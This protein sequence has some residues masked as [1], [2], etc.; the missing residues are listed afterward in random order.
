MTDA[1]PFFIGSDV[2]RRPGFGNNHPLAIPR[3]G[4]VMEICDSMD[5]FDGN[6][7]ESPEADDAALLRFHDRDYLEAV[8]RA[9]R[10]GRADAEDRARYA[11]GTMEN[12]IFEGL[13]KRA[14]TTCGG[15]MLAAEK[16]LAGGIAFNPAGGTHHGM[17]DRAHGFC[18]FND[19]VMAVMT[20]LDGGAGSVFYL[21]LDAHH[22]DGVEAAF[23]DE[24]RVVTLSIHERDRWP[25]TGAVHGAM[26]S[27]V[28]NYPVPKGFN[29]NELAALMSGAVLPLIESLSPDAA[30]VTCGADGLAADPLSGMMLSNIAL[31]DAVT[32]VTARVPGTVVLGGGGYNPWTVARCWSGFWGRLSGRTPPWPLTEEIRIRFDEI[33]CDL[34]DDED[35]DQSWW[36]RIEDD[37]NLAPVRPEIAALIWGAGTDWREVI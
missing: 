7:L 30:V 9:A 34:I 37:A 11:L 21:D 22:G 8:K 13:E 16:A 29:D 18:Y 12:P 28:F 25:G 17:R 35:R 27:G 32:A 26:G 15:S 4:L 3:V 5:W 33:D 14:R 23:A 2:Y 10:A 36:A 6:Y 24:P 1:G 31:W 19:P 20:L